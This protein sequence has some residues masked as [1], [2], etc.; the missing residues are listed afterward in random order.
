MNAM[1]QTGVGKGIDLEADLAVAEVLDCG[2]EFPSTSRATQQPS[3]LGFHPGR[4]PIER[5]G[6]DVVLG[7][8]HAPGSPTT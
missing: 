4:S 7:P 3:E 8:L 1:R 5:S 2:V 6:P